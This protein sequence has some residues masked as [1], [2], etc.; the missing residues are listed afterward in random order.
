MSGDHA[1][2]A[3]AHRENARRIREEY[4]AIAKPTGFDH[5]L[6]RLATIHANLA[7]ALEGKVVSGE[8][9]TLGTI[10]GWADGVHRRLLG[11][12]PRPRLITTWETWI[13]K[14]AP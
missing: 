6:P 10:E 14:E 12:T 3:A 4:E 5:L 7:D 13:K 2:A 8:V 9:L 1:S 11:V